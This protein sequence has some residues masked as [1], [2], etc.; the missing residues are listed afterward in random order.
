MW[1]LL[2]TLPP[3]CSSLVDIGEA[4]SLGAIDMSGNTLSHEVRVFFIC[5]L[6][7]TFT[8]SHAWLC[9]LPGGRRCTYIYICYSGSRMMSTCVLYRNCRLNLGLTTF[10]TLIRAYSHFPACRRFRNGPIRHRMRSVASVRVAFSCLL[11]C[12]SGYE[13]P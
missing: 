1:N 3:P 2:T 12:L 5:L 8:F 10:F 9:S 7:P 13:I 11:C 6:R 4:T